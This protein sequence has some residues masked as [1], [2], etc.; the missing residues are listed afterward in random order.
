MT[1]QSIFATLILVEN[2]HSRLSDQLDML[3]NLLADI[4][5]ELQEVRLVVIGSIR[6]LRTPCAPS[7]PKELCATWPFI[8]EL[9]NTFTPMATYRPLKMSTP[10]RT[11]NRDVL[12]SHAVQS[13]RLIWPSHFPP[14]Q[15]QSVPLQRFICWEIYLRHFFHEVWI[16]ETLGMT[17]KPLSCQAN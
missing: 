14:G 7:N 1:L 13:A 16:D 4:P 12:P 9:L 2:L 3:D 5:S 6:I 17:V 15:K 8:L 10:P 11:L